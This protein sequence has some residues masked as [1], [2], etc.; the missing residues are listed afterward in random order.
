M[1]CV[2]GER[3][4]YHSVPDTVPFPCVIPLLRGGRGADGVEMFV[5]CVVAEGLPLHVFI[6]PSTIRYPARLLRGGQRSER[7]CPVQN[8]TG[9]GL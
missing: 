2:V 6:P 9:G 8:C 1:F 4:K 3:F 5:I 7:L